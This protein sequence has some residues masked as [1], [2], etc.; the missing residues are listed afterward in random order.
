MIIGLA[1]SPLLAAAQENQP[2]I[3]VM[4]SHDMG[5]G[6]VGCQGGTVIPTPNIDGY[7]RDTK[8]P[9]YT[10]STHSAQ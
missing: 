7:R 9:R 6:Q 5:W 4:L 8:M 10:A 2:N 3:V 1:G